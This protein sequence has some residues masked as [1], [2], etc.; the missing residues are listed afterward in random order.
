VLLGVLSCAW[1]MGEEDF[2]Q[3]HAYCSTMTAKTSKN[4][5]ILIIV[6]SG[7]SALTLCSIVVLFIFNSF[8]KKRE[9]FHLNTSYQLRE[10]KNVLRVLL[11]LDILQATIS[12]IVS[13]SAFIVMTFKDQLTVTTYR[14]VLASTYLFPYYTIASPTLIW[15]VIRWSRRL[16]TDRMDA[17]VRK[18]NKTESDIY[19]RTYGEMWGYP[20]K[21]RNRCSQQ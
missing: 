19:F 17:M 10:N 6:S 9:R 20:R 11:P 16:E 15:F 12:G 1:G 14:T 5:K 13:T 2:S 7:I 18:R 21:S 3:S 4:M 8:A